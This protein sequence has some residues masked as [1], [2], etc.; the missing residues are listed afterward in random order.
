M[1]EDGCD[2]NFNFWLYPHMAGRPLLSDNEITGAL[3][4]SK[5]YAL[6]AAF[7]R[8]SDSDQVDWQFCFQNVVR[9][10]T[11]ILADPLQPLRHIAATDVTTF[12]ELVWRVQ[13][14][15]AA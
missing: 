7:A 14:C 12:A 10:G 11:R 6:E 1:S 9:A 4:K 2:W 13:G 3:L 8:M 5:L 15:G